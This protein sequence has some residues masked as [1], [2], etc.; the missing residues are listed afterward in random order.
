[1]SDRWQWAEDGS[2][3]AVAD[4]VASVI[5]APGDHRIAVPG[6]S[7]P[8]AIFNLLASRDLPWE[9]VTLSLTDDRLVAADHPASNYGRLA[10]CFADRGVAVE[11]MQEGPINPGY[12]LIWLG[13][14]NDGHIASLFPKMEC[15]D[16][17]G[18]AIIPTIPEPLPPEAPFPRFSLNM[19]AILAAQEIILVLRGAE[20]RR[21]IET[22]MGD[23]CDLPIAKLLRA[24]TSPL[25]I[26]WS[27]A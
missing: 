20:K 19:A 10:D 22:A 26:F 2:S 15:A 25:T 4:H 21:V 6:G 14:G 23:D 17:E 12:D 1:M 7:T 16:I 3:E 8:F 24:A 11:P 9:R 5:A 18:P 13:M 27:E